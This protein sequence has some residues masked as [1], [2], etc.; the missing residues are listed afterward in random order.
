ME[1]QPFTLDG[2]DTTDADG[3]PLTYSWVQTSGTSVTINTAADIVQNLTAP[4]LS[5]DESLEFE[6]TVSDGE[7]TS[8]D[9]VTIAV[10]DIQA[11]ETISK[12]TT[13]NADKYLGCLKGLSANSNGGYT[14]YWGMGYNRDSIPV[15]SQ[16][17]TVDGIA[18]GPQT[19]GNFQTGSN[20]RGGLIFEVIRSGD[21]VYY[22]NRF[23]R[24]LNFFPSGT[25]QHGITSHR[26]LA[27]G[28]ISGS[29]D[30][31]TSVSTL[32]EVANTAVGGNQVVSL[33]SSYQFNTVSSHILQP[34]GTAIDATL[35]AAGGS[36][37]GI[38]V[39]SL[40]DGTYMSFWSVRG[41]SPS[42]YEIRMQRV[43]NDGH[44]LG[45]NIPVTEPSSRYSVTPDAVTLKNGNV[46]AAWTGD[47]G[48]FG[49]NRAIIGR[50]MRPDGSFVSGE[51]I[52]N[53]TTINSQIVPHVTVLNAN[54]VLVTWLNVA[55][56][57]AGREIRS[58]VV[59]ASD[60][61]LVGNEF[62]IASGDEAHNAM[63]PTSATL[64]DG[65]VILGWPMGGGAYPIGTCGFSTISHTVG[66]YP[67]G[68]K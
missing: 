26:G 13:Y 28:T 46:F 1:G 62:I 67:V 32:P 59:S 11:V 29:G 33:L 56:H 54:Q 45:D 21:T 9:T 66:L 50:I 8:T 34:D 39:A 23:L 17:F 53:T 10:E 7:D 38:D 25:P 12:P 18:S 5:A 22:I 15:S 41:S 16:V 57:L 14:V 20:L 55:V 30:E 47:G 37:N 64:A 61:T 3:D 60:G 58:Q 63:K 27:A 2:S 6:L 52:I 31:F 4:L 36:I 40:E 48:P 43:S 42:G 44:L 51:F 49:D 24:D 65:R 68:K 19:D 35:I